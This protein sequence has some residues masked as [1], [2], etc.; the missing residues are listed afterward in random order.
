MSDSD[1]TLSAK[2]QSISKKLRFEVFKRD[3]FTCQYCGRKAPDVILEV[4]HIHPVSKGGKN[5]LLNYITS[6]VDCNQGKSD[7]LL[8]DDAVLEKQRRQLA[9]LQERREQIDMMYE[10]QKSLLGINQQ[11]GERLAA[12]WS[13][14]CRG[15]TLNESGQRELRELERRFGFDEVMSAIQIASEHY[16]RNGDDGKV[17]KESVET[18]WKKIGGVLVTRKRER[19]N[20]NIPL[21]D[22]YRLRA[23]CRGKYNYWG[24]QQGWQLLRDAVGAGASIDQL[25][26]IIDAAHS[27][28]LWRS[29]MMQLLQSLEREE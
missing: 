6:C 20:P 5:D 28:T 10:W 18:A 3:S 7:R 13:E 16:L 1:S 24:E 12:F 23:R 8:S 22:L 2:R 15:W 29:E 19:D 21:Q 27:W 11:I 9:E 26:D 14:C 4:D 17:T 25:G